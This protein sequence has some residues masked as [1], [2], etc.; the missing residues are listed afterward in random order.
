[1]QKLVYF[2]CCISGINAAW[3]SIKHAGCVS[4]FKF[5]GLGN[6]TSYLTHILHFSEWRLLFCF[7]FLPVVLSSS[8]WHQRWVLPQE[9]RQLANTLTNSFRSR[10][11]FFLQITPL[12]SPKTG[13][14]GR[15]AQWSSW[16]WS[17]QPTCNLEIP[18]TEELSSKLFLSAEPHQLSWTIGSWLLDLDRYVDNRK[19]SASSSPRWRDTWLMFRL[20]SKAIN[21]PAKVSSS[22][23]SPQLMILCPN[24][25]FIITLQLVTILFLFCPNPKWQRLLLVQCV[26]IKDTKR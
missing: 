15:W 8:D 10:H 18:P 21:L 19:Q 2:F 13:Q 3:V 17:S 22:L 11:T 25:A 4:L 20:I 16:P 6:S 23:L 14:S 12:L 5:Q 9:Q 7:V 1:M 24:A 26:R